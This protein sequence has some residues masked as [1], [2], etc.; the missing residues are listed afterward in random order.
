MTAYLLTAALDDMAGSAHRSRDVCVG[1]GVGS[2]VRDAMATTTP[3]ALLTVSF[4]LGLRH[5]LDADHV[6][7]VATITSERRSA[8]SASAVGALW[9]LGHTAA[10]LVLACAVIA[11]GLHVPAQA[12]N[13]LELGVATML[14]GLGGRSLWS[15]GSAGVLHSHVHAHGWRV[16]AHPHLHRHV[17]SD[18]HAAVVATNIDPHHGAQV[19][20]RPLLVGLMH[21]AA[22]SAAPM[23][24][25]LTTIPSRALALLYVAVFGVGSIAG[26]AL[27]SALVGIPFVLAGTRSTRI[28][29]ALRIGAALASITVGLGL[30]W[31]VGAASGLGL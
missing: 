27:T 23:M 6:A 24:I 29:A 9:G 17:H 12:A 28:T 7:A 30:A 31:R 3:F 18:A 25:V 15:L 26:M 8:W 19:W 21:G 22:G 10:L 4:V 20:R 13:A 14:I 11:F 1:R 2:I 5:A 16:H